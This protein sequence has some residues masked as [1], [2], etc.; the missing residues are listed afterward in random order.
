MKI[1]IIYYSQS[2][3]TKNLAEHILEGAKQ[4]EGIEVKMM[5][6]ENV[7]KEFIKEAKAIL[8][9][10]PTY[11]GTFSW[12]IKKWFDTCPINL[13][14]KLGSLFATGAIV[15]G[16]AD[17]AE[18]GLA[19]MMLVRGMLVYTAGHAKGMPFTHLGAVALND[20]EDWQL[21][22]GKIL[23]QRVAEKAIELFKN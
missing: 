12:Q 5:D 22:R 6:V 2:G 19:G 8:F 3:N 16:G 23:G 13:D 7:D 20:G 10:T 15:G 4:V 11:A 1:A 17:I 14:G 9:G 18:H 21:E